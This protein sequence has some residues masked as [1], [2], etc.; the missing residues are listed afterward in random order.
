[1]ATLTA[2]SPSLAD[3]SPL[4]VV[5]RDEVT[6]RMTAEE[7]WIF[8]QQN[9]DLRIEREADQTI[10]IMPP[11]GYAPGF[12]SGEAFLQLGI[13]HRQHQAGIV[14]DSSTGFLLSDESVRSPDAAWV[15]AERDTTVIGADR[16]RFARV[17]PDFVIEVASPSDNIP[18]VR[19][20]MKLW[21][22]NGVRLGFLLDPATETAWVYRPGAEPTEVSGFDHT[23]SGEDVLSG[24]VLELRRLQR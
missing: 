21:L 18:V 13:W 3:I 15:S 12:R 8:C 6:N 4:A 5:L 1:M 9:R 7:F 20:K 22:A 19:E 10:L 2:P 23:L 17:C 14:F 11:T 16:E 24:F